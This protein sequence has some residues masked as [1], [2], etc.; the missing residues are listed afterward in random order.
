MALPS[1][2]PMPQAT[3]PT[4]GALNA[5]PV[6]AP[7]VKGGMPVVG[8]IQLGPDETKDLLAQMQQMVSARETADP[9]RLL[10]S[11]GPTYNTIQN[12]LKDMAAWASGGFRGPGEGLALRDAEKA[13][14]AKDLFEM[15]TQMAAY[16]SA[17]KQAENAA[18]NIAANLKGGVSIGGVPATGMTYDGIAVP[19]YV[20]AGLKNKSALEQQAIID[21]W[22]GTEATENIKLRNAP[23]GLE[24][25]DYFINGKW[26]TL[27]PVE[28]AALAPKVKAKV[29]QD[30]IRFSG[31]A[32]GAPVTGAPVTGAPVT[33]DAAARVAM[34]ESSTTP[35]IKYHDLT[36]GTAYG[37]YGITENAYKDIQAVNPTFKDRPITSLNKDEQTQAFNTYRKLTTDQFA[38]LGIEPTAQNLDLGHFLGPTGAAQ[39]LK[40]KTVSEKAAASN[41]GEAKTKLIADAILAGKPVSVSGATPSVATTTTTGATTSKAPPPPVGTAPIVESAAAAAAPAFKFDEPKPDPAKFD[42]R[43]EL[44]Q[45]E[46]DWAKRRD[47]FIEAEKKF[48]EQTGSESAKAFG[49]AEKVFV[50]NTDQSE[51]SVR[52]KNTNQLDAWM[53]RW[54]E[55]PRVLEILSKPTF[56]NAVADALQQG[57]TTPIGGFN[58]PG[59]RRLV[60]GGMPGLKQEEVT[61]LKELDTIMGPRLFQIVKQSKGSS[62]DKDW[63]AYT[64]IAGG[65]DTGYDF[66][67]K[68]IKYDR[69][70]LKTDKED[71]NLYNS[72]I[73]PNQP[74]DFRGFA[75]NPKRN[76]IYDQYQKEVQ[77]IAATRH[78]KQKLPPRPAGMPT[79]APA[80]WSPSTQSFWI[81]NKEYKVK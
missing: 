78:E 32:V 67:N 70:S 77:A 28:Y 49:D 47:A 24:Q 25:K 43:Y 31:S 7:T 81:G 75:A 48:R 15:R 36:K 39:Y 59:I 64:Q 65:A 79:D 2:Q 56:A 58:I 73:K 30:T 63:N 41:G 45:A 3:E 74:T 76:E 51:L 18:A 17:Q 68:A 53:K 57:V 14:E 35:D 33:G 6:K 8:N 42:N 80:Q 40:D 34:R 22:L 46:E 26:E 38:K 71:R 52:E 11:G 37:T 55:N 9:S 13:R 20:E 60:Q 27:T 10:F 62:S 5:I 19:K 21:K 12:S 66:L 54:G 61:A 23:A 44:K 16:K 29:D 4:S 50:T 69:V 1:D 72:L